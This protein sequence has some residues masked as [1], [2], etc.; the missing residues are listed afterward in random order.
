MLCYILC[1]IFTN[2]SFHYFF[3]LLKISIQATSFFFSSSNLLPAAQCLFSG[4]S[5]KHHSTSP[6]SVPSL[7]P[8]PPQ[9]T[10]LTYNA[11]NSFLWSTFMVMGSLTRSAKKGHSL[12]QIPLP[13]NS[14]WDVVIIFLFD[15]KNK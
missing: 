2:T 1:H 9:H 10:S 11:L 3:F 8:L 6:A 4:S 13:R 12:F 7:L 14:N 5:T 15:R